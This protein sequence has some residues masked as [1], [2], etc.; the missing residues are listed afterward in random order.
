MKIGLH[1]DLKTLA[2]ERSLLFRFVRLSVRGKIILRFTFYFQDV[3]KTCWIL[4]EKWKTCYLKREAESWWWRKFTRAMKCPWLSTVWPSCNSRIS[5][6]DS[7]KSDLSTSTL[8][9]SVYLV[10]GTL[11]LILFFL[12]CV[13]NF[14]TCSLRKMC[15]NT[16]N[17]HW[18][19]YRG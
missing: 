7:P 15:S 6:T 13:D 18:E 2:L 10:S 3:I 12:V 8:L 11:I 16:N 4:Y 5:V 1:C 9:D 19:T 17:K 14:I